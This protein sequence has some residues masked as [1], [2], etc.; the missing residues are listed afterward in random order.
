MIRIVL[1]G[2]ALWLVLGS[3]TATALARI[4]HNLKRR[5]R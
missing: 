1:G 2:L 5:H 3:I 4:A